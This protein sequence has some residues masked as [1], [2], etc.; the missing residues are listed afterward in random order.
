M[1]MT[2]IAV[3]VAIATCVLSGRDAQAQAPCEFSRVLV[4]SARNEVASVLTSEGTV[5][6]E[7]RQE[8]GLPKLLP[9]IQV[10]KDGMICARLATLFGHSLAKDTRFVVLK[11]GPLFYAREP[12]QQFGTGILTDS[13]YKIVAKLGVPIK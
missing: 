8:Q 4:D 12:Y 11:I 3:A 1:R 7:I 13:A 6:Q 10:V 2:R 5:A 9:A